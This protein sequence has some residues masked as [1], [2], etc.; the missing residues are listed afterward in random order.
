MGAIYGELSAAPSVATGERAIDV[1]AHRARSGR[2]TLA[3]ERVFIASRG[4]APAVDEDR[5]QV[6]VLDGAILNAPQL[7]AELAGRGHAVHGPGDAEV[8]LRAFAC[9]GAGFLERVNGMFA[10]A[11]W[12]ARADTLLLARDRVGERPLY[13]RAD[14]AGLVFASRSRRSSPTRPSVGASTCAR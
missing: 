4:P 11:I 6:A 9:W 7:R 3:A 12:G 10:I 2:W 14:G 1:L 5:G 8:V 13:Y